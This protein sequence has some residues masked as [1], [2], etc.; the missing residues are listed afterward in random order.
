MKIPAQLFYGR[1]LLAL[2]GGLFC[3]A[4]SWFNWVQPLDRV[5]YDIFNE[6]APLESAT[7][8]II[9]AVDE[10]S[11]LELGRWP[12]PRENHVELMRQLGAA[13]V[14]AVAMDVLFA[15]AYK[16]YPT[17]D[18]L[19]ADELKKLDSVVLPVFIGQSGVTGSL[20]EMPPI[21]PFLSTAAALG[22][23]HIEVDS[24]GVARTVYL[25]EGLGQPRWSHFAVALS[26]VL[27]L[28]VEPLPGI[29]D[30]LVL[31]APNPD[32]IIRSHANLI[33]F[34]GSAGTVTRI[35]YVEVMKGRLPKDSLRD[36]IVFV[37]ATAAGHVDN[38]TTSL[39]QIPGVEINANIFH[40]L[41]SGQLAQPL[42]RIPS[43]LLA[44]AL[45]S[46]TV[47]G[48]TRLAPGRLLLTVLL[49]AILLP[50]ASFLCLNYLRLWVSPAP[51][52]LTLLFVYPLWNW[53]RLAAAMD[54][55][56]EQLFQLEQENRQHSFFD[57]ATP[58]H[59]TDST[60]PVD[61]IMK[62]LGRAYREARHNHELVRDT[63]AQLTSGVILAEHSGR[64]LMVN[65]EARELLTLEG[66][67]GDLYRALGGIELEGQTDLDELLGSLTRPGHQFQCE[68]HS[69]SSRKDLLLQGGIIGLNRPLLL[70][71]LTDVSEL[72]QSEKSRAEALNFL[73]H[74]LRAPLTS[75]LALIESA[76]D[77]SPVETN[78][79]LLEQ[80]EK[81]IRANL[82]YAENFI[83]LAKLEQAALPRFDQCDAQSLVDNAVAQLYHSAAG[84][85][86]ELHIADSDDELWLNCSRDL[87]ERVL[88]NLIDNA[89][90]HSPENATVNINVS[91]E[92]D[93]VA[94]QVSDQGLGIDPNDMQRIFDQFHQG[95]HARSGAGLGLRFVSAVAS[96]H[97]GSVHAA[98]NP[99]GGSCFT[100]RIPLSSTQ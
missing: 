58:N 8:I 53:L 95:T 42:S 84:R 60:D 49:A 25:R 29:S 50:L 88:I 85:G 10:S 71:V 75:V 3:A 23:V 68:G 12:W 76:R 45:I 41:R 74:D 62:Q 99:T 17:V 32:A 40:A 83:Q 11:L 18:Q 67:G 86:I 90:K 52:L 80:I 6:V 20:R 73:S 87:V 43:A 19:L 79:Q 61:A 38:I 15:E 46:L 100:L 30:D 1:L 35:P 39:G 59:E 51:V 21:A 93:C 64:M 31:A 47:F 22:H 81:Y 65:D 54:F 26:Q 44:F 70:F 66:P 72:K 16:E 82:S 55:I 63:M 96:A 91:R 98:N 5:I 97:G 57:T 56:Q 36:K 9:V 4:L 37:G 89:L 27:G 33:P 69:S 7:D 14:S 24:D 2:V 34:M 13:G 94:F 48:F 92:P 77:T 78:T 28:N